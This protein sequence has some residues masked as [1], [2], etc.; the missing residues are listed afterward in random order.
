MN[1]K[2]PKPKQI[3]HFFKLGDSGRRVGFMSN[4]LTR[5]HNRVRHKPDPIIN[6]IEILNPNTT[7]LPAV[8]PEHDPGKTFTFN[9]T[10]KF[11]SLIDQRSRELRT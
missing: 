10:L 8:L 3:D 6:R 1:A 11:E 5:L 7:R 4:R 2:Q 9:Q